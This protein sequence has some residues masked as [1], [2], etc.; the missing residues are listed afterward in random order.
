MSFMK[1]IGSVCTLV[2][3]GSVGSHF[4]PTYAALT[5]ATAASIISP[6]L[7]LIF[8]FNLHVVTTNV[9]WILWESLY[10]G[11]FA[12]LF[13]VNSIT[14]TYSSIR[15]EYT[16]WWLGTVTCI[17]VAIG[18]FID[19]VLLVRLQIRDPRALHSQMVVR[20]HPRPAGVRS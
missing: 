3:L 12:F 17:L 1:P 11:S 19:L 15:W 9:D 2:L 10:A 6:A 13:V 18:F 14:M 16:A 7:V 8:A 4:S 5:T 20:P